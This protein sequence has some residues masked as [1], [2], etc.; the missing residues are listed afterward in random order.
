MRI[1]V[2]ILSQLFLSPRLSEAAQ[3]QEWHTKCGDLCSDL[4]VN[5]KCGQEVL[6]NSLDT[7]KDKYCCLPLGNLSTPTPQ[8]RYD[9]VGDKFSN[10]TCEVGSV[11]PRSQQCG[12]KCYNDYDTSDFLG[13]YAH[14][15]CP[16]DTCLPLVDMCQGYSCS[17]TNVSECGRWLRCIDNHGITKLSSEIAGDHYYCYY[18][19]YKNDGVYHRLDRSDEDIPDLMET[20]SFVGE[21]QTCEGGVF[22]CEGKCEK[23]YRCYYFLAELQHNNVSTLCVTG[24]AKAMLGIRLTASLVI[25]MLTVR[26]KSFAHTQPYGETFHVKSV[27]MSWRTRQPP[28]G[29]GAGSNTV[30]GPGIPRGTESL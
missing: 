17:D 15:T 26:T 6:K 3:C 10:V 2:L 12:S 22:M 4:W 27:D 16:D 19:G 29:A 20:F 21:L 8:C 23:N 13:N 9:K 18:S 25:K 7:D 14:Y 1:V 28:S 11:I 24:S 5:C 30:S